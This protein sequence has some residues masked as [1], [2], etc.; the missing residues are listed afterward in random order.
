MNI[1]HHN[2]PGSGII[3]HNLGKYCG[4]EQRNLTHEGHIQK[5]SPLMTVGEEFEIFLPAMRLKIWKAETYLNRS[6]I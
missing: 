3:H 2:F 5:G 4:K 1:I 6:L